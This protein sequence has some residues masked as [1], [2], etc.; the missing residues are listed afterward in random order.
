MSRDSD[1]A[2]VKNAPGKGVKDSRDTARKAIS[3]YHISLATAAGAMVQLSGECLM[4]S[5]NG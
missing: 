3:D 2:A 1:F 5:T 4:T